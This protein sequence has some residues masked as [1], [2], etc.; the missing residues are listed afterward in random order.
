VNRALQLGRINPQ[1]LLHASNIEK[2]R[3]Y[4]EVVR[5]I[6]QLDEVQRAGALYRSHPAP[7]TPPEL[8]A[9]CRRILDQAAPP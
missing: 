8:A 2:A 4:P 6:R 7:L 3:N 5:A 9:A 1:A